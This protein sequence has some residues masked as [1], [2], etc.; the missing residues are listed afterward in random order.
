M[1][2]QFG[3]KSKYKM[4]LIV[5]LRPILSV[6]EGAAYFGITPNYIK[7]RIL[8]YTYGELLRYSETEAK[9]LNVSR[10]HI[11]KNREWC[12][13][14][15]EWY[16]RDCF[17]VLARKNEEI[18]NGQIKKSI[19]WKYDGSDDNITTEVV[20]SIKEYP[21]TRNDAKLLGNIENTW[22]S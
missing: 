13:R 3:P 10:D 11:R 18:F 7:C 9:N 5:P 15:N 6:V 12:K 4:N 8:K 21:K 2:Q 14:E 22:H 19:K 17:E 16:V 20:F 1:R